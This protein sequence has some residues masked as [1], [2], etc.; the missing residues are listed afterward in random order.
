MSEKNE[1]KKAKEIKVTKVKVRVTNPFDLDG[2]RFYPV[3][4]Y[5]AEIKGNEVILLKTGAIYKKVNIN[6]VEKVGG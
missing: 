3:G 4:L 2:I 5:D 6:S 1:E